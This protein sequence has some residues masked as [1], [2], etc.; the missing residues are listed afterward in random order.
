MTTEKCKVPDCENSRELY[1][2]GDRDALSDFCA[3]HNE[4]E[5]GQREVEAANRDYKAQVGGGL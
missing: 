5:E 2:D 4:T 1:A 3:Y